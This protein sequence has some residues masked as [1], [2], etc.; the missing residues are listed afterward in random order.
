LLA[1]DASDAVSI[2]RDICGVQAQLM[3]V[4]FLQIWARDQSLTRAEIED[5]LWKKRTLVMEARPEVFVQK[6]N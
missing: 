1:N 5:A 6:S 4:A 3:S 2:C